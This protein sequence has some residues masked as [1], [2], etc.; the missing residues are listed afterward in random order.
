MEQPKSKVYVQMDEIGRITRC[1]GGCTTPADLTGWIYID[2]GTG[3]KYGL[4]QSHYFEGGLRTM[5]GIPRYKLVDGKPVE[6]TADEI[7]VDLQ[8]ILAAQARTTRDKLLAD[9]DWTQ[10]LDAPISA[11][12]REAMRVYRQELRDIT[13]QEGFPRAVQWP[14]KPD[15]TKDAPDPVDTAFDALVGGEDVA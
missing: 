2:E 10:T 15:V 14:D 8:P 7:D 13:E 11:E 5:E 6:R 4:C 12:S 3:D 9:T 1:E